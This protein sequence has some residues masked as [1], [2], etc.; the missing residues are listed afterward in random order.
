MRDSFS[1]PSLKPCCYVRLPTNTRSR[2][3]DGGLACWAALRRSATTACIPHHV[4]HCLCLAVFNLVAAPAL[5]LRL[6][7]IR[8][9]QDLRRRLLAQANADLP[10]R[11][12]GR[13]VAAAGGRWRRWLVV[14]GN[15]TDGVWARA[16][17]G[18]GLTP[19]RTA[20]RGLAI[21]HYHS[22]T[23]AHDV[24]VMVGPLVAPLRCA[25]SP[26]PAELLIIPRGGGCVRHAACMRLLEPCASIFNSLCSASGSRPCPGFP[27]PRFPLTPVSLGFRG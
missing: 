21:V 12:G 14:A 4:C 20:L 6:L 24:R 18:M 15:R 5:S 7:G 17:C 9:H 26:R 16:A 2:P 1:S 25:P 8:Q 22:P 10:D 27:L 23:A 13:P 19:P 11:G 3:G